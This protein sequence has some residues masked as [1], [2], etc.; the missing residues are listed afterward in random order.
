MSDRQTKPFPFQVFDEI[1]GETIAKRHLIKGVLAK[2]E[3]SSWIAPPGGMKSALMAE[4]ATCVSSGRDWRGYKNKE[5]AGVI[6][7]ALERAD[8]VRRRL[9]A[10]RLR[11]GLGNLPI[12]LVSS[13]VDLMKPLTVNDVLAT[14]RQAEDRFQMSA[15]LVIFDTFAKLIAAGGGD[16]D[17]ARDQGTVFANIQRLKDK[18]DVHV[19]LVGHM[20]K[21]ESRGSRGSNA[22]VGDADLMVTIRG[23]TVRT[24]AI[25]KANDLPEGPLF[26]FKTE[27]FDF[28]PDEDGDP[29]TVNIVAAEMPPTE[30]AAIR[31]GTRWP[32]S[33]RLVHQAITEAIIN[34]GRSHSVAGNGPTVRAATVQDARSVHR[35]K[36]VSTGDGDR[37]EAERKAWQRSFKAARDRQLVSGELLSGQELIWLPDNRD[38]RDTL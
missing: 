21:D 25:Y 11:D 37:S 26:S 27:N 8:L 20:G 36:Y 29:V 16:E 4:A 38:I 32:N 1:T 7:F 2:G 5:A 13:M 33:L 12:A 30:T 17:K 9:R 24:A 19:A 10:H 28:G 31:S 22:S 14:I 34:C 18:I 35:T 3:T 15:G 23:D 6:Y